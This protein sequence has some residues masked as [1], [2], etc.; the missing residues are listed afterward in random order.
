MFIHVK[1]TPTV[2]QCTACATVHHSHTEIRMLT[3]ALCI[4]QVEALR[5]PEEPAPTKRPLGSS[6]QAEPA[7]ESLPPCFMSPRVWQANGYFLV[8]WGPRVGWMWIS[9]VQETVFRLENRSR[10]MVASVDRLAIDS[11]GSISSSDFEKLVCSG[12]SLGPPSLEFI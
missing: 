8:L 2:V 7:G 6:Q 1:D 11:W 9:R 4:H 12:L 10:V 3:T 5:H